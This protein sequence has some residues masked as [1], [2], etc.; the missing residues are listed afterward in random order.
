MPR[1]YFLTQV[2]G[3]ADVFVCFHIFRTDKNNT[4]AFTSSSGCPATP[5]HIQLQHSQPVTTEE[6]YINRCT[7]NYN[8]SQSKHNNNTLIDAHPE[9]LCIHQYNYVDT[10]QV[11][12]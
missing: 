10:T 7:Y 12:Q 8:T 1:I 2:E 11:N 5:M 4:Q 3:F 6:L 9:E